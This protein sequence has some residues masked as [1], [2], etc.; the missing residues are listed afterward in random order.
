MIQPSKK[1]VEIPPFLVMEVLERAQAM[2]AAGVSVIHM[3]VGEPDFD[4]PACVIESAAQSLREGR[5]HYTHSLGRRELR[6][7]IARWHAQRYG[8]LIDPETIVVTCGSVS[9]THL[10]LPTSYACR[11]RWSPYH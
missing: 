7:A 6:E 11:S 1:S 9:Y 2:E 10:T 4:S 8:T 5:T 3:E